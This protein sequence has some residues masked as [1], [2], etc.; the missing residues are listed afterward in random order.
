MDQTRQWTQLIQALETERNAYQELSALLRKEHECLCQW[1][2]QGLFEITGKKEEVVSLLAS[3]EV[4]R[5]SLL[6]E[7]TNA[8]PT[9]ESYVFP[10]FWI[11]HFPPFSQVAGHRVQE[12]METASNAAKLSRT[13]KLLVYR[14]LSLVREALR[15]IHSGIGNEPVYGGAGTLEFP[16]VSSSLTVLG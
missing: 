6:Q 9:L 16:A 8:K 12:L 4:Q 7:L 2:H 13:N 10:P 1:N 11:K 5:V 14:G 15:L 3:L